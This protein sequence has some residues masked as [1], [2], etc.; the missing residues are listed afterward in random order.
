MLGALR[1][2]RINTLMAYSS[3]NHIGFLILAI[4]LND[5]SN[6]ILYLF[7]YIFISLNI[8]IIILGLIKYNN[9]NSLNYINQFLYLKKNN[10]ILFTSLSI[11]LFS[12]AGIPPLL[13]FYSKF[14][15]FLSAINSNLYLLFV[16]KCEKN[17]NTSTFLLSICL[18]A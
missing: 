11:G 12:L 10:I 13:G 1:T 4:S 14:L 8:F 17:Q 9:Y 18:T 7:I 3:I 5:I 16:L 15:I 2:H 6:L